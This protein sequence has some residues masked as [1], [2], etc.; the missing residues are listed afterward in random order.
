[1]T[2]NIEGLCRWC[3][4]WRRG[5]RGAMG[6]CGVA[7]LVRVRGKPAG[8]RGGPAV[9]KTRRL[10]VETHADDCCTAY[11]ERPGIFG[12]TPQIGGNAKPLQT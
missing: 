3:Q 5:K 9:V 11:S 7:R 6:I 2:T 4:H 10:F 8:T 1:M 12:P